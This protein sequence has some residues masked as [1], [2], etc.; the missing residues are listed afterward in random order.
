MVK[1]DVGK[2][3]MRFMGM[4]YLLPFNRRLDLAKLKTFADETLSIH[5]QTTNFR[6][7]QTVRVCRR[8]F[9]V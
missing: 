3:K 2:D 4:G 7:F 8:L 6:L 9:Q 5:Y 1:T